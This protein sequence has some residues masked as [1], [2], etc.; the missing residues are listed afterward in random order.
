MSCRV[1]SSSSLNLCAR[2]SRS[3]VGQETDLS[4]ELPQV[5]QSGQW[6]S[7]PG[8]C[9]LIGCLGVGIPLHY[10]NLIFRQATPFAEFVSSL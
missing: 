7:A 1:P 3:D 5:R 4:G 9:G 10:E 6:R 2:V 8:R